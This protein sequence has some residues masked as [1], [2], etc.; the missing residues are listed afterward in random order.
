MLGGLDNVSG[1]VDL[2]QKVSAA[3]GAFDVFKF[4]GTELILVDQR[5]PELTVNAIGLG[6]VS[7]SPAGIDCGV[8]TCYAYFNTGTTVTL[9]AIP[10]QGSTF[11]GWSGSCG[12]TSTQISVTM[13]GGKSCTATFNGQ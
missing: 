1:F 3:G 11:A 13:D 7:S 12:G 5:Q 9:T 2:G 10:A 4:S 8:A 6:T